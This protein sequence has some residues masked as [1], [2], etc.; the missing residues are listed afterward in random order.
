MWFT[1]D[2]DGEYRTFLVGFLGKDHF[3]DVLKN[4]EREGKEG[5]ADRE[6]EVIAFY[7]RSRLTQAE[8]GAS[9]DRHDGHLQW[10]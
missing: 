7:L 2:P 6:A 4:D 3:D 5:A 8:P 9:G 1:S 10:S